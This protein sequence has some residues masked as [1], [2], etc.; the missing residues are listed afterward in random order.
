MRG[1]QSS[2][3]NIHPTLQKIKFKMKFINFY[4]LFLWVV[5]PSWIRILIANPD[6]DPI[7]SG[8][9]SATLTLK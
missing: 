5:L 4:F 8:S 2:K 7:E 9:G 1:H 6:R 3:E